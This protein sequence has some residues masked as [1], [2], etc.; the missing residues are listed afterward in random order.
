MVT[1]ML[2]GIFLLWVLNPFNIESW[3]L[4]SRSSYSGHL[5][6]LVLMSCFVVMV[7][8]WLWY[9]L[10]NLKVYTIYHVLLTSITEWLVIIS[11]LTYFYGAS[12][13]PYMTEWLLTAKY[14]L[15]AI[16]LPYGLALLCAQVYVKKY[17]QPPHD[18]LSHIHN[19]KHVKDENGAVRLILKK[20]TILYLEAKSNYVQLYYLGASGVESKSIRISLK[21]ISEQFQD[22]EMVQCH[23]SFIIRLPAVNCIKKQGRKT[24]VYLNGAAV[25][26]PVSKS[27]EANLTKQFKAHKTIYPK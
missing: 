5:L 18:G 11:L 14:F 20:S 23:R 27:Y 16:L 4:G 6:S 13:N 10:C 22:M 3:L 9:K 21:N 15:K 8:Q 25:S 17:G 12:N 1:L 26:I 24:V 2:S 7:D 19:M